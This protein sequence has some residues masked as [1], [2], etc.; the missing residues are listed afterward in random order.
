MIPN[1][2]TLSTPQFYAKLDQK[3]KKK[4]RIIVLCMF[5]QSHYFKMTQ[6]ELFT[7]NVNIPLSY[8]LNLKKQ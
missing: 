1:H 7:G 4:F 2:F 8:K 5:I 3:I 6:Y